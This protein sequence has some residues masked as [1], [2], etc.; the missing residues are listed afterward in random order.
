MGAIIIG[1]LILAVNL[2]G[3]QIYRAINENEEKKELEAYFKAINRL[4]IKN[5]NLVER[6]DATP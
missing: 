4:Y 6:S 1:A 2:A 5:K 3:N